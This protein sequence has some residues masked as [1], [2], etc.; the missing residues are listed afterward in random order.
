MKQDCSCSSSF[1]DAK[2][3]CVYKKGRNEQ[4]GNCKLEQYETL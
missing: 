2:E 3:K 1:I 4:K